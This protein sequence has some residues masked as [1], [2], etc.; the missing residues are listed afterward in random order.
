MVIV[1]QENGQYCLFLDENKMWNKKE[2]LLWWKGCFKISH[3]LWTHYIYNYFSFMHMCTSFNNWDWTKRNLYLYQVLEIFRSYLSKIQN[4]ASKK[5][6]LFQRACAK[7][8]II[9]FQTFFFAFLNRFPNTQN[10]SKGIKE[11]S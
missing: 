10:Y 9:F 2:K 5:E 11:A 6:L 8:H 3:F 1:D 7:A 4:N